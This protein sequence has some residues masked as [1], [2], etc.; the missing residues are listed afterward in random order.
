HDLTDVYINYDAYLSGS[1]SEGFGLTLLESIA[2]GLPIIGFDVRYGN[3]T[4]IEDGA[5]G[6]IID[7]ESIQDD[8]EKIKLLSD[9]IIK[10][11]TEDDLAKCN[12]ASYRI[13]KKY[14]TSEV[15]EKWQQVLDNLQN[16]K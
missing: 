15:E 14:L 3:K 5:N 4:F 6:Y 10:L 12:E 8:K 9:K 1:T 13:A 16:E 7:I 11:F 2:S